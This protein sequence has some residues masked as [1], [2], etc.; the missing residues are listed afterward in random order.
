MVS[1]SLVKAV[2]VPREPTFVFRYWAKEAAEKAA[3]SMLTLY[4]FVLATAVSLRPLAAS[5]AYAL[6]VLKAASVPLMV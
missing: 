3:A 4:L 1:P 6:T 2:P 5:S